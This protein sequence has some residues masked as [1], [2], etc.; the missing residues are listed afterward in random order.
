MCPPLCLGMELAIG[1]GEQ[2]P[3]TAGM[4]RSQG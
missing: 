2:E 1:I 4:R 3:F